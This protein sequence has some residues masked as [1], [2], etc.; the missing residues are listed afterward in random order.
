[1]AQVEMNARQRIR[2]ALNNQQP[3]RVP[4]MDW[5]DEPT[6]VNLAHHLGLEAGRSTAPQ[7]VMSG[8]ESLENLDLLRRVMAELGMDAT[9][10][11]FSTGLAPTNSKYARDKYGRVFQ[12]SEHG[13]PMIVA[14]P[15]EEAADAKGYD[16]ASRL[17]MDDLAGIQFLDER[18]GQDGVVLLGITDPFQESWY[19]RGGMARLMM[20]LIL[21]PGLV[22]DLA[23]IVTDLNLG[24]IEM[25]AQVGIEFIMMGGDLAGE[26]TTLM[27]P[28]HYREFIKPY[29]KELVDCAHEQ[30]MRIAKHT[31]GNAWPILDDFVEIGFDGFNP[32]QPDCMDIAEVKAHLNSKMCII[33]NIDCRHLLPFGTPEEVEA[34]VRETISVAAGGGY[35]LASSNSLHPGCRPEN[36][37]AMVQA[38]H[39]YGV[40]RTD[41]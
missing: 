10:Y 40:Y 11:P 24:V 3:D 25:A 9:W 15:I 1:M 28:A 14:G 34:A 35:I 7:T 6:V 26:K 20:D 38:A 33:G 2:T 29:Q 22:H 19:L 18:L 16:M 8:E 21:N 27:S 17:T 4:I 5:I 13:M 41:S 30:G 12:L 32:I 23:R 37:V 36:I 31:D 39:E